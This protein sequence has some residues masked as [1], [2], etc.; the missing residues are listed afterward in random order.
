MRF[1]EY[2]IVTIYWDMK[3]PVN[4]V[5]VYPHSSPSLYDT[6]KILLM[7]PKGK[8]RGV[9]VSDVHIITHGLDI[10]MDD[11]GNEMLNVYFMA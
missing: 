8:S 7:M 6:T 1:R 10:T 3:H 4:V 9:D 5:Y 2:F 11:A